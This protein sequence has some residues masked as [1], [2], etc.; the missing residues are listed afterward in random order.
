MSLSL[1][2]SVPVRN[3]MTN[4][5]AMSLTFTVLTVTINGQITNCVKVGRGAWLSIS[6][7][8]V[9]YSDR[10]L[11]IAIAA[12]L[13]YSKVEC[14]GLIEC[15]EK[16][17]H[18]RYATNKEFIGEWTKYVISLVREKR[19]AAKEIKAADLSKELQRLLGSSVNALEMALLSEDPKAA[20]AAA[21]EVFDRVQGKATQTNVNVQLG[22]VEHHVIHQMPAKVIAGMD[23]MIEAGVIT[24]MAVL[25]AE[26]V[27]PEQ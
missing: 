24:S 23:R 9:G 11:R 15:S 27:N 22:K 1:H 25:E 2:V 13:G 21:K 26:L 17:I 7:A 8:E 12:G 5:R 4:N 10:D 20:L 19:V 16:T 3:L 18:N 6:K 14:A